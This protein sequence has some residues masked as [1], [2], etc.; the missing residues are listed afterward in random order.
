MA[1]IKLTQAQLDAIA[2][3]QTGST[4]SVGAVFRKFD[5]QFW[6]RL[7]YV[8]EGANGNWNITYDRIILDNR[9]RH[10]ALS[11]SVL[12]TLQQALRDEVT[13]GTL[14]QAQS[15][16]LFTTVS[17]VLCSLSV[18]WLRESRVIC[19]NIATTAVFTAGRKNF[20]LARIDEA[21][22]LL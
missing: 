1:D 2:I 21:I 3:M 4:A 13:N 9:D 12:D 6:I 22:A 11:K 20:M 5:G 16:T 15:A 19:N 14:T 18:G 8:S 17:D 10:A 7:T